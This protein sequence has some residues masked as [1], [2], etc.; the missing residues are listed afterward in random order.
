MLRQRSTALPLALVYALLVVYASLYP[1]SGWRWPA[2]ASWSELLWLTWPPWRNRFDELSNFL[3][4][5]PLGALLALGWARAGVPSVLGALAALC[6]PALLSYTMEC[7]QHFIPRRVPS[8]RDW[9]LNAGG[10]AMGVCLALAVVWLGWVTRWRQWRMRWF[11]PQASPALVLLLLWPVALLFPTPIPL[12]LGQVFDEIATWLPD[13]LADTPWAD[14][15]A[16]PV[17]QHGVQRPV[18][19]PWLES[20]AVAAG[21]MAPCMLAFAVLRPGWRRLFVAV[22]VVVLA[23][24]TTALSTALNFGPV[25]AWAWVTPAVSRG[26][27]MGGVLTLV[28]SRLKPSLAAG[29]GLMALA[30]SVALGASAPA[31]PYFA[32]SLQLWEQGQ[33]IRFHGMSQWVGWLWPYAAM[34]W[35]M[36]RLAGARQDR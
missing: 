31:D 6:L 9:A 30:I 18:P 17:A 3:G 8:G 32:A 10:A 2:G 11:E 24:G 34:T 13:I 20:T 27:A 16:T 33:F 22:F 21:L 29:L 26:L 1:F 5:V 28:L 15:V 36:A 19:S 7:T 25:H 14:T 12:G 35:L 23:L 4:Y